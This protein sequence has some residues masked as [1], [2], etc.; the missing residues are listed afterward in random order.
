MKIKIGNTYIGNMHPTYFIADIAA[1]HDGN[2][3][4]AKK[5]IK[6]LFKENISVEQSIEELKNLLD[7]VTKVPENRLEFTFHSLT[8]LSYPDIAKLILETCNFNKIKSIEAVYVL[9]LKIIV[10]FWD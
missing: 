1:N 8:S 10:E 9:I 2:L 6:L 7:K 3:G 5:L 4:R